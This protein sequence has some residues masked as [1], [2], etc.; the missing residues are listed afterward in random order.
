LKSVLVI[1]EGAADV[2]RDELIRRTPMAV[3]RCPTATKLVSEGRGG[4]IAPLKPRFHG[5]HEMLLALWC[6]VSHEEAAGIARGPLEW[7]HAAGDWGGYNYAYVGNFVTIDNGVLRE[8]NLSQLSMEETRVLAS[9]IQEFFDPSEARLLPVAG[10]RVVVALKTDGMP[11]PGV[12]PSK[13]EGE[14]EAAILSPKKSELPRRIMDKAASVL[15]RVTVNDVRVDLGENPATHLWLWGGGP[16]PKR[17]NLSGGRGRTFGMVTNSRMASG[18]AKLARMQLTDLPDPWS[19]TAESPPIDAAGYGKLL[20]GVDC[21]TLYIEP[22]DRPDGF[23][24]AS[25]KV[26]FLDRVDLL[27]LAPLL[28]AVA[29][30]GPA[31]VALATDG[32]LQRKSLKAPWAAWGR[33]IEPDQVQHWD[34][35]SCRNG[36]LGLADVADAHIAFLE[37]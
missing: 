29:K 12:P 24:T 34:E 11:E 1:I 21:L 8:G 2:P 26:H 28:D 13:V 5:R 36:G 37:A 19:E 33:G 18:F 27:V 20:A 9:A 6:G 32:F 3:A 7:E 35:A 30:A 31:R 16:A 14:T 22:P 23:G 17:P 4:L 10:G 15:E 25:Q